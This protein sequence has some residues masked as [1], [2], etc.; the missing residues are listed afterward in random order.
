MSGR[1]GRN[2][3]CP[4]GSGRKFKHC[5]LDRASTRIL[6]SP[7]R[8]ASIVGLPGEGASRFRFQAGSYGGLHG[9]LPSVACLKQETTGA[10]AYHFVLVVPDDVRDDEESAFLQAGEHLFTV[11]QGGSSP[12]TIANALRRIGYIS[13]SG[14]H[15]VADDPSHDRGFVPATDPGQ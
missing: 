11:F 2:D 3:P 15:V 13:V 4:C 8:R 6:N 7:P 10:W 14:F 1:V 5:C 9:Y 12:E